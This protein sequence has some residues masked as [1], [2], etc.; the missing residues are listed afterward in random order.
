MILFFFMIL[1]FFSCS[2]ENSAREE[3]VARVNE[4]VLT[5][6]MLGQLVGGEHAGRKIYLHAINRWVEKTLLYNAALVAGLKKDK[7]LVKQ[8][9]DFYADL[10]VSSYINIKLEKPSLLLKEDVSEYYVN[11]K[12]SFVRAGDE[13]VVKHFVSKT[14]K[15]AKTI[16]KE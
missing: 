15:E 3:V 11:N 7:S 14:A 10:L 1:L 13:V 8:K 4:V 5:K 9:E 2:S 6:K 16:K 12:N